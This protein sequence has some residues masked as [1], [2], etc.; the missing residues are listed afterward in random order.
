MQIAVVVGSGAIFN[1]LKLRVDDVVAIL[2]E[3]CVVSHEVAEHAVHSLVYLL[4]TLLAFISSL[5]TLNAVRNTATIAFFINLDI[6]GVDDIFAGRRFVSVVVENSQ[7]IGFF[8]FERDTRIVRL[9]YHMLLLESFLV[10]DT[11]A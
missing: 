10:L 5:I 3:A 1:L 7:L 9:S 8:N 2:V 4:I 11:A 6:C